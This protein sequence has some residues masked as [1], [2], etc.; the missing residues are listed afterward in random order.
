MIRKLLS[1]NKGL[2]LFVIILTY[3]MILFVQGC[4]VKSSASTDANTTDSGGTVP[5]L[6]KQVGASGP[7]NVSITEVSAADVRWVYMSWPIPSSVV[8]RPLIGSRDK[9]RITELLYWVEKAKL[10]DGAGLAS[11]LDGR[12]M[13]VNIEFNNE[14][15]LQI[16]PAWKCNSSKDE[17]GNTET[18]CKTVE[19][20]I[21]VSDP[22][23]GEYFAESERLYRF[24]SKGYLDW[25]PNVAPYEAPDQLK[26]GAK[27]LVRG[28]GSLTDWANVTLIK[29]ND[30]IWE[31]RVSVNEGEW[32]AEGI[33]PDNLPEGDYEW[34]IYT[35]TTTYGVTVHI[36][37]R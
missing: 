34:K 4:G 8:S 17:Q 2:L 26:T 3:I 36:S 15:R 28:H 7:P 18:S 16:R 20:H 32:Q 23:K 27:F 12:S 24:V 33:I 14:H 5:Q 30:T 21:W 10:I 11:P 6:I 37:S 9:D 35:G 1:L 29:G 19:N 13:A 22:N 25:M 31:Q